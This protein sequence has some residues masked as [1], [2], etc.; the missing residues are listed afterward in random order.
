MACSS[1][2]AR[3][4]RH[5]DRGDDFDPTIDPVVRVAIG[6]LRLALERYDAA[7]LN[8]SV[9]FAI[10]KGGYRVDIHDLAPPLDGVGGS[11]C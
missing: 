8:T 11:R 7:G 4:L 5:L 10:P 6:R 3:S 1:R 9:R 2:G